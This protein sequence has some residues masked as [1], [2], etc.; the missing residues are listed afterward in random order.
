[1]SG[2]T[3]WYVGAPDT[4]PS[5]GPDRRFRYDGGWTQHA[6]A[7][8]CHDMLVHKACLSVDARKRIQRLSRLARQERC[9]VR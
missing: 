2:P 4:E 6:R 3:P 7:T 9:R 5:G 8:S 1:M